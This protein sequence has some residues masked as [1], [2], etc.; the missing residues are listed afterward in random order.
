MWLSMRITD[1]D[2]L[3]IT[4]ES[5]NSLIKVKIWKDNLAA[6]DLQ[7]NMEKQKKK[8]MHSIYVEA[9]NVN[10]DATKHPNVVC[11]VLL[12]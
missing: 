12:V 9:S 7:V 1:G 3:M 5:L 4:D 8:K 10:A 2:D 6:K 11:M